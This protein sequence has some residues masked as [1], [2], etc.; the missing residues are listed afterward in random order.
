MMCVY[1]GPRGYRLVPAVGLKCR[2]RAEGKD[3]GDLTQLCKIQS[4]LPEQGGTREG[5][6]EQPIPGTY[7]LS[8]DSRLCGCADNTETSQAR[9]PPLGFFGAT[10]KAEEA[11]CGEKERF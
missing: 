6:C 1:A 5:G 8:G 3:S 11:I 7:A 2:T 4:L 10:G 9:W